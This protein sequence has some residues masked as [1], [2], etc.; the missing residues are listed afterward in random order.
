[1]ET[2]VLAQLCSHRRCR[3]C[4]E[5]E[6]ASLYTTCNRRHCAQFNAVLALTIRGCT[7]DWFSFMEL[8]STQ[9]RLEKILWISFG[10]H[11]LRSLRS[12]FF[13]L[14]QQIMRKVLETKFPKNFLISDYSFLGFGCPKSGIGSRDK[15]NGP[16]LGIC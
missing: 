9:W 10:L 7:N 8:A 16:K 12:F 1:M 15:K 13:N 3:C 11:W 6:R 4:R 5:H 14:S 2:H